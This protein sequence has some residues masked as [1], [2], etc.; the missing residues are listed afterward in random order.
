[1]TAPAL[2]PLTCAYRSHT[3]Q[4]AV[5]NSLA[6]FLAKPE[7]VKPV[8]ACSCHTLRNQAQGRIGFS[9]I[10]EP[11]PEHG[12]FDRALPIH[13]FQHCP[14][15]RQT[16]IASR[17]RLESDGPIRAPEAAWCPQSQIG[18]V[19]QFY[20]PFPRPLTQI[21]LSLRLQAPGNPPKQVRAI[22]RP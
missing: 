4:Q 21:S 7:E 2:L 6:V 20:R 10:L 19:G 17:A 13:S 1:M 8:P 18:I 11:G 5:T 14:D 22:R 16:R 3:G 15:G 9:L 12:H